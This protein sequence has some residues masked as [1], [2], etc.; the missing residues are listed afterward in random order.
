[1]RLIYGANTAA[2]LM[3]QST[4]DDL[5]M[6]LPQLQCARCL[7]Q[8]SPGGDAHAGTPVTLLQALLADHHA[9]HTDWPDIYLCGPAPMIDAATQVA[10]AAG[11]PALQ[12][13]SER[14]LAG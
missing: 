2:D 8:A 3:L 1:V 7:V 13:V 9:T 11:V 12:I 10:L 6:Q 14:F 5:A 4:L